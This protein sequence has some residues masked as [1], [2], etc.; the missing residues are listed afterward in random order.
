V[1]ASRAFTFR[2]S[3]LHQISVTV[4]IIVE[5]AQYAKKSRTGK[6]RI[7]AV[8]ISFINLVKTAFHRF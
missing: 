1:G 5:L 7:P 3:K 2:S 8:S 6:I 4:Q